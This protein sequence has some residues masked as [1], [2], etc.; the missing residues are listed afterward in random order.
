MSTNQADD[1]YLL[2]ADAEKNPI[3]PN[4]CCAVTLERVAEGLE[5]FGVHLHLK[6]TLLDTPYQYLVF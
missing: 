4:P 5:A 1:D 2:A 6:Q 3:A